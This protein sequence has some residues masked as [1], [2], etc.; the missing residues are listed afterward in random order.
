M[1][2]GLRVP[3]SLWWGVPVACAALVGAAVLLERRTESGLLAHPE[4]LANAP[5]SLGFAVVG[6]LVVSRRPEQGLGL[7][8]PRQRD[9]DGTHRLRLRV[10]LVRPHDPAGS[11]ARAPLAALGV[12]L[13]VGTRASRRC[14][15]SGCCSTRTRDC[16]SRRWRWAAVR[17]GRGRRLPRAAGAAFAPGPLVN[18]P[19]RRQP[20]RA[21]AART[22]CCRSSSRARLPAD[23]RRARRRCRGAGGAVAAR[24]GG[25]N[26]APPDRAPA[27]ARGLRLSRP[28]QRAAAGRAPSRGRSSDSS[29]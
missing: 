25:R 18:H 23:A 16:P 29:S 19:R 27:G 14:S 28:A 13:G 12:V 26:A 2:M 6:A 17:L 20:G 1:L 22:R 8:L 9:G 5:L 15:P 10:R 11:G 21:A 7:A 4:Y 3:S 24:A